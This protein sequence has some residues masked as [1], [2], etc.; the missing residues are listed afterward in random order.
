MAPA[1]GRIAAFE[2][3]PRNTAVIA[4]ESM[5]QVAKAPIVSPSPVPHAAAFGGI[6]GAAADAKPTDRP[7]F[8]AI[9]NS[10]EFINL[11]KRFRQFV[12]PM[13]A[14]FFLWYLTYVL[15][16][17]YAR[18]FMSHK[19]VGSVNVGLVLG[20]LQFA[21]TIAITAGYLRFAR[22]HIDPRVR[23]IRDRAGV[24]KK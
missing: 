13:S 7:D 2:L 8:V 1:K 5:T 14:L 24:A 23:V 4:E 11:R 19:L 3:A 16:A 20:L 15:L 21:T 17:A 10:A 18:D 22:K 9:H 12:F 6:T